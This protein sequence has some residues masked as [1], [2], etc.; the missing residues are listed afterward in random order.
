MTSAKCILEQMFLTS[1][2]ILIIS[3][4]SELR[5]QVVKTPDQDFIIYIYLYKNK[6]LRF[7]QLIKARPSP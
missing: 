3:Q 2:M 4:V 6:H 7:Q 1:E 5:E